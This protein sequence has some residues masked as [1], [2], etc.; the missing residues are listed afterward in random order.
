MKVGAL[1]ILGSL[2]YPQYLK[3]FLAHR[4]CSTYLLTIGLP[5]LVKYSGGVKRVG[6]KSLPTDVY[7]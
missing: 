1:A 6:L 3:W 4:I 2:L 5:L 7:L